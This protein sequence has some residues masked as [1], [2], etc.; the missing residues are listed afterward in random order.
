MTGQTG[1]KMDKPSDRFPSRKATR[2]ADKLHKSEG[3][4]MRSRLTDRQMIGHLTSS[5]EK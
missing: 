4:R 2:K 5:V 3:L 1:R